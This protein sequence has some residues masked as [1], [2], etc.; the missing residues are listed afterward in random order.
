MST[1]HKEEETVTVNKAEYDALVHNIQVTKEYL[2]GKA[3]GF[4]NANELIKSLKK[5]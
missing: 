3:K 1:K 2:Q 4:D 5:L